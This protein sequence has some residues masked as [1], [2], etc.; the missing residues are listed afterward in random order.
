MQAGTLAV[1]PGAAA[2]VVRIQV[3]SY[4]DAAHARTAIESLAA[5]GFAGV[6]EVAQPYHRVVIYVSPADRA[7]VEAILDGADGQ[8]LW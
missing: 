5:L 8:M 7:T 2:T 1:A 6:I 3:G 4:R